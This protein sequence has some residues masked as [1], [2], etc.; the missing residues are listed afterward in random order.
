MR[1]RPSAVST[2]TAPQS[3]GRL[4]QDVSFGTV[5]AL[6]LLPMVSGR[7]HMILCGRLECDLPRC[8]VFLS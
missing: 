3:D 2:P 8:C 5:G 4:W 6:T 7:F 1:Q